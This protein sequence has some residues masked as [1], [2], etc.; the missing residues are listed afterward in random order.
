MYILIVSLTGDK[1]ECVNNDWLFQSECQ[2]LDN[3]DT[4]CNQWTMNNYYVAN[5]AQ[6]EIKKQMVGCI[7]GTGYSVWSYATGAYL[8]RPVVYLNS[9][10]T[11]YGGTGTEND[12]YLL[13]NQ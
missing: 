1:N 7:S 13:T 6:L 8:V 3:N 9:T 12:P 11:I 2:K 4:R 5:D 10:A